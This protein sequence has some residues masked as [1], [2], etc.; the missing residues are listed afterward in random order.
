MAKLLHFLPLVISAD[1]IEGLSQI[2]EG[3]EEVTM[4][5]MAIFLELA[6]SKYHIDSSS[7]CAE[8]TLAF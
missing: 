7:F 1:H 3:Q 6:C 2:D 8:A 5:L 4:L